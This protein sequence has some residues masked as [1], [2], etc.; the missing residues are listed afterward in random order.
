MRQRCG[1][2]RLQRYPT[3]QPVAALQLSPTEERVWEAAVVVALVVVAVALL[4]V[5]ALLVAALVVAAVVELAVV[6]GVAGVRVGTSKVQDTATL[7]TV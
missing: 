2:S 7:V 1:P 4:V 3:L 5:V 6:V